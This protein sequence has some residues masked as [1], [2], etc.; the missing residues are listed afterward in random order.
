[1]RLSRGSSCPSLPPVPSRTLPCCLLLLCLLLCLLLL[2]TP[3]T[4]LLDFI[5]DGQ[6]HFLR[7]LTPP[8][9]PFWG[10]RRPGRFAAALGTF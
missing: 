5:N 3:N 2:E 10:S 1:M 4:G 8:G 9:V 7:P 6:A